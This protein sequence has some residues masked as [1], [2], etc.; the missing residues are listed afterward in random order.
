MEPYSVHARS[1][2]LLILTFGCAHALAQGAPYPAKTVR[3][4]LPFSAGGQTDILGRI[5]A[6]KLAVQLGQPVVPENRPGAGSNLGMEL[7]SKAAPD[8]HT[9]VLVSPAIAISPALYKKL[10][11]DPLRDLAPIG[12]VATVPNVLLVHPSVPARNLKELAALARSRPGTLNFGSGG[13]GTSIHL[14]GEMFK[15]LAGID[16][17]HVPYKGGNDAMAALLGGQIEMMVNGVA[18]VIPQIRS[19]R[20][21][22]LAVL[23]AQRVPSLPAVPTA[24][25]AGIRNYE[26]SNWYGAL[27]PAGTPKEII[28]RLNAELTTILGMPDVREKMTAAGIDPVSNTPEQFSAFIR[29]EASRYAQV[30]KT[31]KIQAD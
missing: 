6:Q 24:N 2:I 7:A 23:T 26:A 11:Y 22:G 21:R 17:V 30:I 9:I 8:G 29:S 18:P 1:L 12:L 15:S 5:L 19:G 25:E 31:A 4:I 3:F 20:V 10:S 16:I 13:V 14:A 27:A 28:A